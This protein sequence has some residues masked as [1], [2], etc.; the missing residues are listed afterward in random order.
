VALASFVGSATVVVYETLDDMARR[1][2]L[3][4]RG[5]VARSVSGWDDNHRRIWTWTE[6]VVS[7]TVKGAPSKLVMVKQPGGEADGIGQAVA[8]V[9][10]FREGEDCILFLEPAPDEK[11]VWRVA[12]DQGKTV[13][14]R[15]VD[16]LSFAAPAGKKVA[17]V[18]PRELLGTP[19]QFIARLR[20]AN[21][22]GGKR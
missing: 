9:A 12:S 6:L 19:E 15:V 3:I 5:K 10:T 8:G 18:V 22:T 13:A 11:G 1:V 7:D 20:A 14:M 2:P 4:V 16:G 17:P 21:A